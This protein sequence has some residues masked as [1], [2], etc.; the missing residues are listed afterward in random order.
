MRDFFLA[1]WWSYSMKGLLST[2]PTLSIFFYFFYSLVPKFPKSFNSCRMQ[3]AMFIMHFRCV[4]LG[5]LGEEGGSGALH[6]GNEVMRG[7]EGGVYS[8]KSALYSAKSALYITKSALYS[9]TSALYIIKNALYIVRWTFP[10]IECPLQTGRSWVIKKR[11][12]HL[13]GGDWAK[14]VGCV[15]TNLNGRCHHIY[16]ICFSD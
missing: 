12:R 11:K 15:F 4:I 1:K 2:G 6:W 5:P 13:A 16:W 8:V 10:T 7:G 9:L 3:C 14:G